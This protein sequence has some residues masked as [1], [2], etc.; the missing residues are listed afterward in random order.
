[1]S[2]LWE[3]S[4]AT[5][6]EERRELLGDHGVMN[7]E[8]IERVFDE[9]FKVTAGN[10]ILSEYDEEK[11]KY[12]LKGVADE[13]DPGPPSAWYWLYQDCC[14]G[15]FFYDYHCKPMRKRGYVMWDYSRLVNEWGFFG[16]A[17][18][19][20]LEELCDSIPSTPIRNIEEINYSY[21]RRE[22]I[23]ISGGRGWWSADDESKII[24]P[25]EP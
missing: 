13:P 23:Y 5:A 1:M 3:L 16:K 14:E 17:C 10:T 4:T 22:E 18:Q 8:F 21:D 6:Y 15:N 20:I 9:F 25:V 12:M 19:Q 24:W 2:F 11:K 7:V